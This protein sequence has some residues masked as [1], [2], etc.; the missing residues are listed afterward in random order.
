MHRALLVASFALAPSLAWGKTTYLDCHGIR[1]FSVTL[2]E[3]AHRASHKTDEG[4]TFNVEASFGPEEVTYSWRQE[5][6]G[7]PVSSTMRI[8]RVSLEARQTSRWGP[9]LL[10][11]DFTCEISRPPARKFQHPRERAEAHLR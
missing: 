3:D 2:D 11:Y 1:D 4:Q 5:I 8:S 10:D 7:V 6:G 9:D